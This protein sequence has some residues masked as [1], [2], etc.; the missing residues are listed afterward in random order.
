MTT[1]PPVNDI[2]CHLTPGALY[3]DLSAGHSLR[4]PP[5]RAE[6]YTLR[7]PSTRSSANCRGR[8]RHSRKAPTTAFGRASG[9]VELEH[10]DDALGSLEVKLSAGEIAPLEE[11]YAPH[12]VAGFA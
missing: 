7:Q 8:T 11:P 3:V 2:G 9:W 4:R 1:K 10:L 12:V 6:R 5:T